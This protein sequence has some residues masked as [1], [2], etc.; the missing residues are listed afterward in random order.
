MSARAEGSPKGG[1][2]AK[3]QKADARTVTNEQPREKAH[4]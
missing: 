4:R 1:S 2:R 3:R